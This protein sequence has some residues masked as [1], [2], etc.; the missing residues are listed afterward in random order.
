MCSKQDLNM[1]DQE[2]ISCHQFEDKLKEG[3][4]KLLTDGTTIEILQAQIKAT[5]VQTG[6]SREGNRATTPF[7]EASAFVHP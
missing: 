5:N 3:I 1:S 4:H 2:D 6:N 7:N